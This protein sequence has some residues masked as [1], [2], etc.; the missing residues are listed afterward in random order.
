M[1]GIATVNFVPCL[2]RATITEIGVKVSTTF[3]SP[4]AIA[5]TVAYKREGVEE[6]LNCKRSS[7]SY[8]P[9]LHMYFLVQ[10]GYLTLNC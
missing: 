10:K 3:S 6:G 9:L 8:Y 7:V 4:R 1:T 2:S 5:Y